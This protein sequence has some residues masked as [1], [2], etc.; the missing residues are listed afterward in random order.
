MTA[1]A[2]CVQLTAESQTFSHLTSALNH[3]CKVGINCSSLQ[4]YNG[5]ML[6]AH[7]R[8]AHAPERVLQITHASCAWHLVG[9]A[10][11]HKAATQSKTNT[12][13]CHMQSRSL[14]VIVLQTTLRTLQL[15]GSSMGCGLLGT[16][17]ST[18]TG[19]PER[20]DTFRRDAAGHHLCQHAVVHGG[21]CNQ[22]DPMVRHL[23]LNVLSEVRLK[24]S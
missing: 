19:G 24:N 22:R 11:W 1:W 16:S 15:G 9:T 21:T 13:S 6:G 17:C 2:W 18:I 5:H 23:P 7:T 14:S 20:C 12:S 4:L 3:A 10:S 8:S